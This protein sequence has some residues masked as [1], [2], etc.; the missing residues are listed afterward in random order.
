MIYF[1]ILDDKGQEE[2]LLSLIE[3]NVMNGKVLQLLKVFINV[4]L[5]IKMKLIYTNV[6]L[7][8]ESNLD[9]HD[10]VI[11]DQSEPN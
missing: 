9:S 7:G 8:T 6:L 1:S 10:D 5:V 3:I 11:I 4:R 2:M